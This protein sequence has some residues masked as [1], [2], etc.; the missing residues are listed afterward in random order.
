MNPEIL[1]SLEDRYNKKLELLNKRNDERL[2]DIEKDRQDKKHLNSENERLEYFEKA[3]SEKHKEIELS[4]K[5]SDNIPSKDLPNHF[6]TISKSILLLQKYVANSNIFLRGYDI[7][8]FQKSLLKLTSLAKEYEDKLLPKKKFGFKKKNKPKS[9]II[10]DVDGQTKNEVNLL[11]I[12]GLNLHQNM[13]NL[14]NQKNANLSIKSEEMYRR[15]VTLNN[16][17]K[18]KVKLFGTPSTLHIDSLADCYIFCGPVS[19]SIFIENCQNCTFVIACQQLR[20]HKSSNLNI[21]L[22]VTSRAIME[23]CEKILFAPY[24]L[25]YH[26]IQDDFHKSGLHISAN[27]WNCVDDFNWLNAEKASPNW[28][29]LPEEKTTKN[30]S[31]MIRY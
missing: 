9:A 31:D 2:D 20:L 10:D 5:K 15:D 17:E 7:K 6:D 3:F 18:C 25:L 13:C 11:K 16:L 26:E 19:T 21:Y 23:D 4:I 1:D 29:I 8:V 30:W 14:S 28:A 27:N 22:F 24:N 12:T